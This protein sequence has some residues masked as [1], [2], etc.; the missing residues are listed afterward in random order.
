ML[1][2]VLGKSDPQPAPV[3]QASVAAAKECAAHYYEK[4]QSDE[5]PVTIILHDDAGTELLRYRIQRVMTPR[6]IAERVKTPKP[7]KPAI[8]R[9]PKPRL[10]GKIQVMGV[11]M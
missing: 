9:T 6:F 10:T 1:Y 3:D 7:K 2:S 4:T 5:W 8:R 11:W